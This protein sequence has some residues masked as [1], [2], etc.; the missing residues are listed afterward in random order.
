MEVLSAII[1]IGMLLYHIISKIS[2]NSTSSVSSNNYDSSHN[3]IMSKEEKLSNMKIDE[4]DTCYKTSQ[5][6]N[7]S[8]ARAELILI[9]DQL[10]GFDIVDIITQNQSIYL[11]VR[12]SIPFNSGFNEYST[13]FS[14]SYIKAN[15]NVAVYGFKTY[16][17]NEEKVFYS[18]ANEIIT[19]LSR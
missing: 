4:L 7:Y 15:E 9:S 19:E 8:I 6:S 18:I 11:K 5:I 13:T 14:I 1:T 17:S 12:Y 10:K 2:E 3:R 16:I